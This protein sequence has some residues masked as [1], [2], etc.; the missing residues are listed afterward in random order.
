ME[1]FLARTGSGRGWCDVRQ[2][3]SM[4]VDL[5]SNNTFTFNSRLW[6]NRP[7]RLAEFSEETERQWAGKLA[8]ELNRDL[9]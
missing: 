4:P 2:S 1:K 9:H 6:G 5:S 7:R 3:F 8:D